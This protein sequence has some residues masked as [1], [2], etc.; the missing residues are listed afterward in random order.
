[1]PLSLNRSSSNPS[2]IVMFFIAIAAMLAAMLVFNARQAFAW[3]FTEK[4]PKVEVVCELDGNGVNRVVIRGW[5]AN[6]EKSSYNDYRV[7]FK[8]PFGQD[9]NIVPHQQDRWFEVN[10]ALTAIPADSATFYVYW[11]NRKGVH[12]VPVKYDAT[13]CV[14]PEP[15]P[16]PE[17]TPEP[18]PVPPTVEIETP[19]TTT[20]PPSTTTKPKVPVAKCLL[21][22]FVPARTNTRPEGY[23]LRIRSGY[24]ATNTTS[25]TR[26]KVT[27]IV[28][29]VDGLARLGEN[30]NATRVAQTKA[31]VRP[32]QLVAWNLRV[33]NTPEALYQWVNFRIMVRVHGINGNPVTARTCTLKVKSYDP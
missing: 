7:V 21:R 4:P 1:M 27:T 23:R 3:D 15:E 9:E 11:T 5:L 22:A 32:G 24:T 30:G 12:I 19:V 33:Y 20:K 14:Q 16:V 10:T 13:I 6:G 8:T 28:T 17:T 18:E 31:N 25:R 2:Q 26:T 29:A